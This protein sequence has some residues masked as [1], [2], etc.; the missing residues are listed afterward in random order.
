MWAHL[1]K[2]FLL[3]SSV[4]FENTQ[5]YLSL[6]ILKETENDLTRALLWRIRWEWNHWIELWEFE[7]G[8]SVLN[9]MNAV[10]KGWIPNFA[11]NTLKLWAYGESGVHFLHKSHRN[12]RIRAIPSLILT[13]VWCV[14]QEE[15]IGTQLL[16]IWPLNVQTK[17]SQS[18]KC[19]LYSPQSQSHRLCGLYNVH[20]EQHPP[21]A[22][23]L[24]K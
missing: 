20:S 3:K 19:C 16:E 18:S 17:A 24:F 15:M 6:H 10:T 5:V 22:D 7:S 2:C 14:S 9:N 21:S 13:S 11:S 23:P 12:W 4:D 1:L 8:V